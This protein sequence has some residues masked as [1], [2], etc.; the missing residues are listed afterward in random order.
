MEYVDLII[1]Y[2]RKRRVGVVREGLYGY[3]YFKHMIHLWTGDWV[4]NMSKT[5]EAVGERNNID[6]LRGKKRLVRN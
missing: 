5:N 2:F 3:H 4:N 1:N 6:K